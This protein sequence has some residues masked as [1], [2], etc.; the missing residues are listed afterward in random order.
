MYKKSE[1]YTSTAQ[2]INIILDCYGD[3][4][5]GSAGVVETGANVLLTT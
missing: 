5:N 1:A 4:R 3:E 2:L